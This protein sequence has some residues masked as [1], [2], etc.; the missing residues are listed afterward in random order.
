MSLRILIADSDTLR[1]EY[2]LSALVPLG[3]TIV[4]PTPTS[5][6]SCDLLESISIADVVIMSDRLDDGPADQLLSAVR[7]LGIPHL[8]L[9]GSGGPAVHEL[10]T[11]SVLREPFASFQVADWVISLERQK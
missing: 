10:A 9:V 8:V 2:V 6:E 5:S 4:G 7:R 1:R 11:S 3:A